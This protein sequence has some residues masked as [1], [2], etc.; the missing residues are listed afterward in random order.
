[1]RKCSGWVTE[2]MIEEVSSKVMNTLRGVGYVKPR[3]DE[4]DNDNNPIDHI[5]EWFWMIGN[6]CILLFER[7]QKRAI[8]GTGR[9]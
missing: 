8:N 5:T 2:G 6:F 7:P 9:S 1:M 4:N 3:E